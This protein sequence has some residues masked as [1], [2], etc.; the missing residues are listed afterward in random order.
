VE[1]IT[2]KSRSPSASWLSFVK[3][4]RAKEVI[5]THVN[6]SQRSEL[7]EKGRFILNSYLL[8]NFWK[9][10]DKD[11]TILAKVDGHTLGMKERDD[12]LVQI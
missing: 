9:T 8:K 5:R 6:K 11:M 7:I 1:I 2:E 12:L 10:L 3:T 4:T